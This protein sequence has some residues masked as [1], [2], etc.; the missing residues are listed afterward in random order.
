MQSLDQHWHALLVSASYAYHALSTYSS[1]PYTS[2][3]S[4]R[5]YTNHFVVKL[6]L[7]T[8][9]EIHFTTITFDT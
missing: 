6:G 5:H 9:T 7:A 1:S 3:T 4:P 2:R 8:S